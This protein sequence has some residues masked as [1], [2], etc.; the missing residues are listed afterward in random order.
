MNNNA[1]PETVVWSRA[2]PV[3]YEADV[4]VIGGGIAAACDR[5]PER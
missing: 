1:A 2:V 4:A 3:R 5:E